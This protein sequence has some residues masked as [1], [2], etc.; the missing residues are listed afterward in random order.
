M[1]SVRKPVHPA[2][3]NL[4]SHSS[5]KWWSNTKS[6]MPQRISMGIDCQGGAGDPAIHETSSKLGSPGASGMS[7]T[8]R[9][10][11]MRCAQES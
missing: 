1:A 4:R 8:K 6:F 10:M 9:R 3:G 5:R 2:A 7:W 11:A